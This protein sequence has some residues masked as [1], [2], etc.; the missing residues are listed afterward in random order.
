M[1]Q[2]KINFFKITNKLKKY[3]DEVSVN[4]LSDI[5]KVIGNRKIPLN[6]SHLIQSIIKN[7]KLFEN[8]IVDKMIENFKKYEKI[9]KPKKIESVG[10]L[11]LLSDCKNYPTFK[12]GIEDGIVNELKLVNKKIHFELKLS[13]GNKIN[14]FFYI[15]ENEDES[16]FKL[17]N[18]LGRIVFTMCETFLE[19][20]TYDI[21][22]FNIR[23]ILVDF[24]RMLDNN[25]SFDQ[26]ADLGIFNNSSGYTNIFKKEMVVSRKSGLNGLLIHELIHLLNIDFFKY[27]EASFYKNEELEV[28][29]K[30]LWIENTNIKKC[31]SG[32]GCVSHMSTNELICNTATSYFLSI[33]NGIYTAHLHNKNGVNN[34]KSIQLYMKLF[35]LIEYIHCFVNCN[36]VLRYFGFNSYSDFFG[37]ISNRKYHQKAHVY[38]YTILRILLIPYFYE[39]ILSKILSVK[40]FSELKIDLIEFNKKL[41]KL[42]E[43][44]KIKEMYDSVNTSAQQMTN[45]VEYFCVNFRS[46]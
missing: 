32:K 29:I 37:N 11:R 23:F 42:I 24:P 6:S 28:K 17:F 3:L 35:Y 1:E 40:K 45:L 20:K 18:Q 33:Y 7:N 4:S 30:N 2:D 39:L 10:Y 14:L 25:L 16:I 26:H 27:D 44:K 36:K 38:E 12:N 19:S 31:I 5:E 8:K 41:I 22:N 13:N 34:F 15:K 21:N 46:L 43:D 9:T